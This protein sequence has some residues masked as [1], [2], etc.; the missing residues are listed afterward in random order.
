MHHLLNL[1]YT[2]D[3]KRAG[4]A[5]RPR[6]GLGRRSHR[7]PIQ[8]VGGLPKAATSAGRR[9]HMNIK[10]MAGT[11][12]LAGVMGAAGLGLGAGAAQADDWG[13]NPGPWG[14][15]GQAKKWCS[16]SV[17]FGPSV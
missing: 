11:A 13:P 4:S 17:F 14:P 7:V 15:P 3:A 12:L 10:K 1:C 6:R 8:Q 16:P 2:I 5:T 9:P